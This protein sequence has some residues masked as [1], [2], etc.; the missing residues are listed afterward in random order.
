MQGEIK[1]DVLQRLRTVQG[2]VAGLYRMVEHDE[3]CID[4]FNQ[5]IAIQRSLDKVATKVLENHLHTCVQRALSNDS[6]AGSADK[7]RV[8]QELL[9]VYQKAINL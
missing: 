4:I 8:I 1:E 3:Y 9:A 5:I 7:E 2:H 6:E